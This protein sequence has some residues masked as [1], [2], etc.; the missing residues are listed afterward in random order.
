MSYKIKVYKD[1]LTKAEMVVDRYPEGGDL[2][3][4]DNQPGNVSKVVIEHVEPFGDPC[5]YDYRL[6]EVTTVDRNGRREIRHTTAKSAKDAMDIV[7]RRSYRGL[8]LEIKDYDTTDC[9]EVPTGAKVRVF[10]CSD[11]SDSLTVI[12][13]PDAYSAR[14]TYTFGRHNDRGEL[15]SFDLV[16]C[17]NPGGKKSLPQLWHDYGR[18]D[19]VLDTWLSVNTYV[20]DTCG[21]CR[22]LYNPQ[23]IKDSRSINFSWMMEDTE[24]NRDKIITEIAN[25]AFGGDGK[26]FALRSEVWE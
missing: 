18:M 7:E 5:P 3:F 13:A 6:Y 26:T 23:I 24:E 9:V 2:R 11:A 10:E 17:R 20:T 25:L 8:A 19:R 22:G 21:T 1:N 12:V 16:S 4:A 14:T 15:V